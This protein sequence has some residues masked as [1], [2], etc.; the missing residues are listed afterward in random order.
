MTCQVLFS[1]R[2]SI[3]VS[4]FH[5]GKCFVKL[6]SYEMCCR[7]GWLVWYTTNSS[8]H[9][10]PQNHLATHSHKIIWPHTPTKSSGHTLSQ[11]HLATHSRKIIWPHTPT[12]FMYLDK[13]SSVLTCCH[14]WDVTQCHPKKGEGECVV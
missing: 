7:R 14:V 6:T 2:A 10:H 13:A 9:T 5:T 11:N 3:P 4:L 1:H 8:G 12:K